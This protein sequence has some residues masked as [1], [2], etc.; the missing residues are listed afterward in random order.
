MTEDALISL[1]SVATSAA[2]QQMTPQHLKALHDSAE[3]AFSLPAR[4]QWGSKAAAHAEMFTLLADVADHPVTSE[5]PGG[6]VHF[7]CQLIITV[8]PAADGMITSSRRRL[9][10]HLGAG[11]ADEA[12]LEMEKHLRGLHYMWRLTGPPGTGASHAHGRQPA[13]RTSTR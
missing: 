11:H 9:L 10:V 4:P 12:A 8:G 13:L 2:C 3:Y 6:A 7:M 1:L 5:V